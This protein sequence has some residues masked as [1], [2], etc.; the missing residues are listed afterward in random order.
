MR[1]VN[2]Q[3]VQ[4]M[5]VLSSSLMDAHK[6]ILEYVCVERRVNKDIKYGTRDVMNTKCCLCLDLNVFIVVS[7]NVSFRLRLKLR[8]KIM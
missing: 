6:D 8:D 5:Y 3:N 7:Y 4:I 2:K 1:A